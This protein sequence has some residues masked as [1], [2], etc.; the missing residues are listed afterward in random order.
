MLLK[1]TCVKITK[2][3]YIFKNTHGIK[4]PALDWFDC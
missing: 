1:E 4:Q 3:W 2:G